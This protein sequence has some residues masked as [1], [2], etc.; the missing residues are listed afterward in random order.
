MKTWIGTGVLLLASVNASAAIIYQ[1]ELEDGVVH[2]GLLES[3]SG[4]SESYGGWVDFWAFEGT[5]GE[6]VLLQASSTD[7][8]LAFSVYSGTPDEFSQPFWFDNQGDWDLFSFV[9][10]S[11]TVGDELLKL[12]LPGSGAFTLVLGG[13]VA[14]MLT[15]GEGPWGYQLT[16]SREQ[17]VT[18]PG[19]LGLLALGLAGLGVMR[20]RKRSLSL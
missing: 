3:E 18:S 16:L 8:D 9:A 17:A 6:E 20:I 1:G 5:A 12:V 14:P 10:L 2:A 7:T 11:S 4:W 15:E 13:E 19:S